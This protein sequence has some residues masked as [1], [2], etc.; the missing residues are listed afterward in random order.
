[1]KERERERGGGEMKLQATISM[2]GE[3]WNE[4]KML[5]REEIRR[6]CI[7]RAI[8]FLGRLRTKAEL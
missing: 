1:M 8:A 7:L 5:L 6:K 4:F 2:D 3:G